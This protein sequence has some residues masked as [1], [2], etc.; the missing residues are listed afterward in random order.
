M[1]E[2]TKQFCMIKFIYHNCTNFL[3][4][5]QDDSKLL[6]GFPWLIIFKPEGIKQNCL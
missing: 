3:T 2:V 5:I 4:D 1:H 6:S